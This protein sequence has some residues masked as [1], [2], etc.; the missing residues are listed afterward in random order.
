[1]LPPP[2]TGL[3]SGFEPAAV[4]GPPVWPGKRSGDSAGQLHTGPGFQ[5]LPWGLLLR[6]GLWPS[7]PPPPVAREAQ[8]SGHGCAQEGARES[9]AGQLVLQRVTGLGLP[10]SASPVFCPWGSGG[11]CTG[12]SGGLHTAQPG[13][14]SPCPPSVRPPRLGRGGGQA[15]RPLRVHL[16]PGTPD[17]SLRRQGLHHGVLGSFPEAPHSACKCIYTCVTP[18]RGCDAQVPGL[19]SDRN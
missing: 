2:P 19:H 15:K 8:K 7:W 18:V 11:E 14:A 16:S 5:L 1:M 3:N 10:V 17:P 9:Q 6:R 4:V 12:P 13:P